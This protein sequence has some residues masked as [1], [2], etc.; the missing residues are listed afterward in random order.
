MTN[1]VQRIR[2][3]TM[4]FGGHPVEAIRYLIPYGFESFEVGGGAESEAKLKELSQQIKEVIG[5]RD[6]VVVEGQA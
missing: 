3:G 6:V 5:D 2:I 1:P 4:L